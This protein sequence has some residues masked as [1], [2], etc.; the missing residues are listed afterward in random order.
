MNKEL[1]KYITI[2]MVASVF[3][4]II[5]YFSNIL[6][7]AGLLLHAATPLF[8]GFAIAYVL[9]LLLKRLEKLYFPNTRN[10]VLN[11]SRRPACIILSLVFLACIIS[12][13][14]MIVMPELASSVN[15]LRKELPGVLEAGR[16][17]LLG[18]SQNLPSLQKTLKTMDIDWASV[19]Q[20]LLGLLTAGAGGIF[21][22]VL[23]VISSAFGFVTNLLIGS[24]FALYL[25]FNKEKLIRQIHKLMQAWIRPELAEKI[26]HV[27]RTANQ[28]F[29]SFIVG[30][31]TEAVI[32]GFLC[33][34]G[35]LIFRF[36][37]AAM[38]G[39]VI[40]VSA[41]IPIVGA[42]IGAAIGAFMIMTTNPLQAV[43][44]LIFLVILQQLEGN[45]IYPRV[46]GSSIGLPG[47]WVLAAITIG[48]GLLGITGMI[49]SVP[50]AATLYKLLRGSV[51]KKLGLSAPLPKPKKPRP[52]RQEA[53]RQEALRQEALRQEAPRQEVL[54][55]EVPR[56]PEKP[57][58]P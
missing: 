31:C 8:T 17:W 24:I 32:L 28:T 33:T 4:L 40:G 18:H 41:L 11:K 43:F 23:I 58:N 36:P 42:Y 19:V 6:S 48:G 10:T 45:L 52:P 35:M 21:N 9:N 50:A 5:L 53:L 37:Y 56:E 20:K 13:I 29:S 7:A 38:I 55:Q 26:L 49:V 51:N 3:V 12:L 14:V 27:A 15:L 34:I 46:V 39:T 1:K 30:Q 57:D 44:F 54:G 22:S 25:L 16:Q 47:M 2:G